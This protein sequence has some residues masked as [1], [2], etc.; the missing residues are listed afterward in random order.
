MRKKRNSRKT[1]KERKDK[2]RKIIFM[3]IGR[4]VLWYELERI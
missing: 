4:C 3:R 1:Q 2:R